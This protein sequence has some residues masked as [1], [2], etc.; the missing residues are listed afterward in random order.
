MDL[1]VVSVHGHGKAAE[2][3]VILKVLKD[4]N[5]K[6][7]LLLDTTYNGS[8]ITDKNR[9]VYWFPAQDV[10]AGDQIVL[11]TQVGTNRWSTEQSN[12]R[13]TLFWGLNTPVWND[14]GDAACLMQ[15]SNWRTKTVR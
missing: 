2:E 5:L 3:Y 15:I 13:H 6:Y 14:S 1:E 10:K 4:C 8:S 12:R 9:H 7:S 11:R